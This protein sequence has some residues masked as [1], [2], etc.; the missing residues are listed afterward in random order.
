MAL[1]DI[2]YSCGHSETKQLYGKH[3]TRHSYLAWAKTCG[4][5]PACRA[6]NDELYCA[7]VEAEHNL[8]PLTG[9]EKQVKWA[10]DIRAQKVAKLAA[11]MAERA[12]KWSPE[13]VAELTART[14]VMFAALA[15]TTEARYWIDARNL[16]ADVIGAD[17]WRAAT[18]GGSK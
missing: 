8:P 9:S 14:E 18:K 13:N 11:S 16:T 2:E 6:Q 10:R 5:C 4:H 12:E 17:A 3:D 15:A 7:G 1:Y